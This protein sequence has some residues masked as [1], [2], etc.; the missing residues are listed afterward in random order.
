MRRKEREVTDIAE[1]KDVL[2]RCFAVHLG[3]VD[4]KRVYVVPVNFGYE[5]IEGKY[6]FYFHGAKAGR[7]YELLK[8][9]ANIGFESCVDEKLMTADSACGYSAFYS[10]IIGEGYASEILKIEEKKKALNKIMFKST[11]NGDW[12]FPS[13]MLLKV[14]VFKIEVSS[15]SCKKHRQ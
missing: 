4:E 8:N 11:G 2:D 13:I 10:S 14:A 3:I 9:G 1:I 5:E 15:L 12:N 7:K 6:V